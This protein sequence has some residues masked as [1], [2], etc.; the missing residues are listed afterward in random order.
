MTYNHNDYTIPVHVLLLDT[1]KKAKIFKK[2]GKYMGRKIMPARDFTTFYH[3]MMLNGVHIT[4]KAV[5]KTLYWDGSVDAMQ[6]KA[7]EQVQWHVALLTK[8]NK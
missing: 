6:K 2:G 8:P 3:R 4:N 1:A 5:F 7:E